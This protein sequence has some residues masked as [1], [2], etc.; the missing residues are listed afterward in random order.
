MSIWSDFIQLF[1]PQ[2]CVACRKKLVEGETF[3][4]L[5]CFLALVRTNYVNC[6]N[7]PL[8][9]LFAGR[10]PFSR[11]ASFAYFSKEGILQKIV[12]EL[13]YANNPELGDFLGK[14]IWNE[15]GKSD[16]FCDIDCLVPI[17]LHPKR[18][19]QRGY[20]QSFHLAKGI[21]DASGLP[22]IA[23]NL[24]RTKNN[25]SQTGLSRTERWANV[26][27]IFSVVAPELLANKHVL[28]IDDILTTGSTIESC[29]R[30]ILQ[31][32]KTRISILTLGS[33]I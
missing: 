26:E 4:C 33:T 1:F 30:Q 10:L 31:C 27:N 12:H 3:I 25:P 16:F 6:P 24:L 18:I 21:C 32:S 14:L 23:D 8:E 20:N 15:C 29:A 5:D 19:K 7:N 17:P 28:L 13:K 22:L 11:I 9:V 2:T